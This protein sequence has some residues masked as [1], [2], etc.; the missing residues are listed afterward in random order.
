M[1][2]HSH[3]L[4][5]PIMFVASIA[6]FVALDKLFGLASGKNFW[7]Y[8]I[9]GLAVVIS[10]LLDDVA[11]KHGWDTWSGLISKFKKKK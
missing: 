10:L 2:K 3:I 6:F 4:K 9:P 11:E 1:K 7:D 5:Y 8:C